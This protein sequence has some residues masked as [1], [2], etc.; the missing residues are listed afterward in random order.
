MV[1]L[2]PARSLQHGQAEQQSQR[3][4][5]CVAHPKGVI[6][7]QLQPASPLAFL[8]WMGAFG[9]SVVVFVLPRFLLDTCELGEGVV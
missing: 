4:L 2:I 1:L 7:A 9:C 8:S 3:L 6:T 5:G